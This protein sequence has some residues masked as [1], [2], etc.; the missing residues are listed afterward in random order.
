MSTPLLDTD[1]PDLTELGRQIIRLSANPS[2]CPE[3]RALIMAAGAIQGS[4]LTLT[5]AISCLRMAQ[6]I[7]SELL[8]PEVPVLVQQLALLDLFQGKKTIDS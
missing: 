4:A 1:C 2:I 5:G 7:G 6:I 8:K 3:A